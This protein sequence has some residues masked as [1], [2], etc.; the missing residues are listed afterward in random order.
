MTTRTPQQINDDLDSL[1]HS[2]GDLKKS[3]SWWKNNRPATGAIDTKTVS[4]FAASATAIAASA[5]AA[6]GLSIT[7]FKVDEKG[8]TILG[9]TKEMPWKKW[10]DALQKKIEN[11]QQEAKRL[12]DEKL[13]T[14]P[15]EVTTLETKVDDNKTH[16]ETQ[17]TAKVGDAKRELEAQINPLKTRVAEIEGKLVRVGTAVS[18]ARTSTA[19]LPSN[20]A[21]ASASNPSIRP[22]ARDVVKLQE[23]VDALVA[24]LA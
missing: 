13:K 9:A 20:H 7:L 14:L 1:K 22:V 11:S 24:E 23:A 6:L 2:V 10:S 17:I 15:A 12:N 5:T 21:G 18:T 19:G 4:V 16:L 3:P 8:I